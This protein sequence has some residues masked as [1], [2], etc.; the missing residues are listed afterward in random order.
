[1]LIVSII[2]SVVSYVCCVSSICCANLGVWFVSFYCLDVRKFL[3]AL[4]ILMNSYYI[5]VFICHFHE[6]YLQCAFS[7]LGDFVSCL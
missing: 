4:C 6:R 3:F 7:V 1:M 5:L 2:F